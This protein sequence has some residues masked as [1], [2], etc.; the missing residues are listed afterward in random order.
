M[1]CRIQ[2]RFNI[3]K[4]HILPTEF[5]CFIWIS[6]ETTI[7]SLYI[8]NRFVFR[9][10]HKIAKSNYRLRHVRPH[11]TSRLPRE[12]FSWNLVFENFPKICRENSSFI[13]ILQEFRL[14]YVKTNIHF[15]SYLAYYVVE[16]ELFQTNVVEKIETHFKYS[17]CFLKSRLYGIMRQNIVQPDRTQMAIWRIHIACWI[18]N[19]T[20]TS[21]Y[22]YYLLL[23]HCNKGCTSLVRL[24]L[25]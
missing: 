10:V 7:I 15:L 3:K 9:L 11:G 21:Q 1:S 12:G 16:W 24:I 23:F 19:A 14:L 22:M 17:N 2:I 5:R 13:I 25:F 6:E 18:H 8:H 20:D 4:F